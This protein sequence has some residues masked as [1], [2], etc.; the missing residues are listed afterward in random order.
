[1]T[2]IGTVVATSDSPSL[3]NIVLILDK[4]DQKEVER[5]QF[6]SIPKNKNQIVLGII[7]GIRK[8]NAYYETLDSSVQEVASRN[9]EAIFPIE[10][11][12]STLLNVKP[13]GEINLENGRITRLKFPVSPGSKIYVASSSIVSKF[14]GLD[15]NGIYLG[16]L[17]SNNVKIKVNLSR[18][19][20]K[21]LAILAISGAGKS[22]AASILLEEIH[23]M[24]KL[25]V[26]VI[27]PHGEYSSIIPPTIKDSNIEII[28]GSFVS[29]GV[30]ELSAWEISEFIPEISIVQTR[31]L[32]TVISE[33]RKKNRPFY[34]LQDIIQ[35]IEISEIINPRTKDALTGWLY[36][37]QRTYL[38]S[39]ESN[40]TLT[41]LFQPGKLVIVDLADIQNRRTRSIIALHFLRNLYTLRVRGIIPPT[42]F[43][44][45][46][47]H[48]FCPEASRSISKRI[49]ETIAREGRKFYASLCLISQ[50]PVNLSVPALS[51]CNTNLI[52]RIR[53]PYDQ[54]FIGRI[55]EGIDRSTLK[56]IPDLEIGEALL[57]GEGINYPTFFRVR[58]RIYY[59]KDTSPNFETMVDRYEKEWRINHKDK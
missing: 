18:L 52:L 40:P 48:N 3:E 9:Y 41:E 12:E 55:S 13:L 26:L 32:D 42:L 5:G 11:W 39:T 38:F 17:T 50:R 49:I 22:Y 16:D 51:Q 21:H 56:M 33:I 46:E 15:S 27:D 4:N 14:L 37:L 47:A 31:V 19:L 44:I 23:K 25:S 8:Y 54:D 57:V 28:K 2:A 34:S 20:H 1:M 59:K 10:E 36:S 24:G 43:V 53:N 30:P 7:T 6:V 29:I 45:E 58:S 35:R